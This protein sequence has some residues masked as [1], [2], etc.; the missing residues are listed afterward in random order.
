[1]QKEI[2]SLVAAG[3]S[4]KNWNDI[5][6]EQNFT[7]KNIFNTKFSGKIT[8]HGFSGKKISYC[9]TEFETGLYN[10]WINESVIEDACIYDAKLISNSVVCDGAFVFNVGT[11]FC[12]KDM[13][14]IR[15]GTET[16]ARILKRQFSENERTVVGRGVV[17]GNVLSLGNVHIG[18][19]ARVENGAFVQDSIVENNTVITENAVV[20]SSFISSF[21]YVGEA[22]IT[23]SFVGPLTQIHHHSLLISALWALGRGNI[24]YGANVGSNHTGRMPDQEIIPGLGQFFGLG[25]NVKF[26]ANFSDAPFTIIATGVTCEPQILRFPFAL[27]K[28][29]SLITDSS[30]GAEL[31][32]L[33][34]IIPGWVYAKNAY[35][36]FRNVYKWNMRCGHNDGLDILFSAEVGRSVIAACEILEKFSSAET[37]SQTATEK[38]TG[39]L[40]TEKSLANLGSNFLRAENIELAVEA[41]QLFGEDFEYYIKTKKLNKEI[42]K[43]VEYCLER[44]YA[45][46]KKIFDDYEE[47]HPL[48]EGFWNWLKEC[49]EL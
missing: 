28:S 44:D 33:N 49:C 46:G 1:M 42:Y 7:P 11:I 39:K 29:P 38:I 4:C 26:P 21:S 24:G 6:V 45:R 14:H 25:C 30:N 40:L 43:R 34:E 37:F 35:G 8:L 19:N 36:I 17:I 18:E 47:F 20:K 48:D 31:A 9:G 27:I 22:E 12:D 5:R 41:Y 16:G 2:D 10:S 15:I 32:G 3:N 13:S 23:S